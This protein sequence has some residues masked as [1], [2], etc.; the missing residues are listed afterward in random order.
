MLSRVALSAA[1]LASLC[2]PAMAEGIIIVGGKQPAPAVQQPS[3]AQPQ[4]EAIQLQSMVS[5][6]QLAVQQTTNMLNSQHGTTRQVIG[7]IR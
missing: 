1:V 4:L 2:A 7:N 6:R 3:Q 5:Q